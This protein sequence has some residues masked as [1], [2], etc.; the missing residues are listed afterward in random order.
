[1]ATEPDTPVWKILSRVKKA[2][3]CCRAFSLGV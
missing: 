2:R 3:P 1:M